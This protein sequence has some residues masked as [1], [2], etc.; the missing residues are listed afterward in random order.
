[1]E[2]YKDCWYCDNLVSHPDEVMLLHL[3]QPRIAV[4]IKSTKY[5]TMSFEDFYDKEICNIELLDDSNGEISVE[6]L[7]E[8]LIKLWNFSA[9]QEE[10]DE[11]VCNGNED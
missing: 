1:M 11:E 10:I 3:A 4:K 5:F 7:E 2:D 8:I 6:E 9:L